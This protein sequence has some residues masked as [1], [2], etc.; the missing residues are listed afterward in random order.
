MPRTL[1]LVVQL[2]DVR[3]LALGVL[4]KPR[5][6]LS[7]NE[8]ARIF[9]RP[10]EHVGENTRIESDSGHRVRTSCD[11]FGR[12][13]SSRGTSDDVLEVMRYP[14]PAPSHRNYPRYTPGG[15]D[16]RWIDD[17]VFE[18]DGVRWVGGL[19]YDASLILLV[20]IH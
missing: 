12:P 5:S 20:C 11:G 17:N 9:L 19:L 13:S 16:R 15:K 10:P 1:Q 2:A 3:V 14:Q 4:N 7:I 18:E 8:N 6:S